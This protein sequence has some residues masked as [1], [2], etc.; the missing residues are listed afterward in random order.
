[1]NPQSIVPWT[2]IDDRS[3]EKHGRYLAIDGDTVVILHYDSTVDSW[4]TMGGHET[5]PEYWAPLPHTLSQERATM[6]SIPIQEPAQHCPR[7]RVSAKGHS[8]AKGTDY[9]I[10]V[11]ATIAQGCYSSA[12][13]ALQSV[14]QRTSDRHSEG[15]LA[16]DECKVSIDHDLE[17]GDYVNPKTV[18]GAPQH[19]MGQVGFDSHEEPERISD[20]PNLGV[21]QDRIQVPIDTARCPIC[22]NPDGSCVLDHGLAGL[23]PEQIDRHLKAEVE[24]R[25]GKPQ[26]FGI[27][28]RVRVE[29][30]D[31]QEKVIAVEHEETAPSEQ[32]AKW[33][34]D[35]PFMHWLANSPPP[36]TG[37]DNLHYTRDPV[38]STPPEGVTPAV[39]V[40]LEEW[41][42][43]VKGTMRGKFVL[44]DEEKKRI[45]DKLRACMVR[46]D[47]WHEYS[48]EKPPSSGRFL[49]CF[50]GGT[51]GYAYYDKTTD[52]WLSWYR[53]MTYK[54]LW[55]LP[56]P[57]PPIVPGVP[58][59][60]YVHMSEPLAGRPLAAWHSFP[61]ELPPES[62]DY[63][64]LTRGCRVTM[65]YYDSE[66]EVFGDDGEGSCLLVDLW[67]QV[68]P[69]PKLP[70]MECCG[71]GPDYIPCGGAECAAC[72]REK[73]KDWVDL[74]D[75][76]APKGMP[77]DD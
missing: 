74:P 52:G 38:S 43:Y 9:T 47:H 36:T 57:L 58:G 67:L 77:E 18:E 66:D 22:N 31:D 33:G 27:R 71:D 28:D 51:L 60:D 54:V 12:Q 56:I 63:M 40:P 75:L 61:A 68:P 4:R 6:A 35:S 11:H 45:Q 21:T 72:K 46:C 20:I 1:M 59:T 53:G 73:G 14:L 7:W 26:A 23:S 34:D 49:V 69:I 15:R 50:P 39:A 76:P 19:R 17:T 65:T 55:W 8:T 64:V 30:V 24:M 10:S 70:W 5:L 16:W 32:S 29:K 2:K 42:D 13:G 48:E 37:F 41:E 3:P 25:R 44:S 62:G